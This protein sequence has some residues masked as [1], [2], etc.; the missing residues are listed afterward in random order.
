MLK[1]M[2]IIWSDYLRHGFHP[3]FAPFTRPLAAVML[4]MLSS[5]GSRTTQLIGLGCWLPSA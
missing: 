2:K 1:L 4:F 3:V 5:P